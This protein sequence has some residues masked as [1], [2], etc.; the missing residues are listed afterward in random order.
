MALLCCDAVLNFAN[1]D[2]SFQHRVCEAHT[3]LVSAGVFIF[4]FF[5]QSFGRFK[6]KKLGSLNRSYFSDRNRKQ[7]GVCYCMNNAVVQISC[8]TSWNCALHGQYSVAAEAWLAQLA[9]K[10]V[11]LYVHGSFFVC[12]CQGSLCVFVRAGAILLVC[13]CFVMLFFLCLWVCV[14]CVCCAWCACLSCLR[15]MLYFFLLIV[16]SCLMCYALAVVDSSIRLPRTFS[17]L[18]CSTN[19]AFFCG[20]PEFFWADVGFGWFRLVVRSVDSAWT[21]LAP[22]LLIVSLNWQV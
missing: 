12:S 19:L 14:C 15:F 4:D 13:L 20:T 21:D 7:K 8:P 10:S 18:Q 1:F 17:S 6:K 16:R 22:L 2:L 9:V 11:F 5:L 3:K